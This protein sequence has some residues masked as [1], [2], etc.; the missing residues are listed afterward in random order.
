MKKTNLKHY[1]FFKNYKKIYSEL[2][3]FYGNDDHLKSESIDLLYQKYMKKSAEDFDYHVLYGDEVNSS[4]I[5][6]YLQQPP[7][8]NKKKLVVVKNFDKL[9]RS[10]KNKLSD[11]AD[12]PIKS[13]ILLLK[14]EKLDN[15]KALKNIKKKSIAVQCRKPYSSK[16]ISMWLFNKLRELNL[17]I[18]RQ[19]AQ[20]FAD[21]VDL[22]FSIAESELEKLITYIGKRKNITKE[23]VLECTGKSRTNNIFELQNAIGARN[24]KKTFRIAANMLEN[25]ENAI[26]IVVMLTRF[27]TQLWTI[28]AL[29]KKN[30]SFKEIEKQYLK[31]IFWMF[32]SDY[33]DFSKNYTLTQ[34]RKIFE[35]LLTTDTKLKSTDIKEEVLIEIL[36]YKIL[37]VNNENYKK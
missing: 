18:D 24:I 7:I 20:I 28:K 22:D 33:I 1:E 16:D 5:M 9:S 30:H 15:T 6:D 19:A 31:N 2:Y 25:N 11:Y 34:I 17:R 12:D 26:F 32:R 3:L 14:A 13:S 27:F 29:R 23:D 4:Q 21:S 10:D 37:R 36:I 8:L 35:Y